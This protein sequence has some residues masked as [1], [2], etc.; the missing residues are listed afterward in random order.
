MHLKV[1][2]FLLLQCL[3]TALADGEKQLFEVEVT[4]PYIELQTGSGRGA[5]RYFMSC[6]AV[7]G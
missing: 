2:T 1:L 7:N 4:E 3:V 5:T 6:T